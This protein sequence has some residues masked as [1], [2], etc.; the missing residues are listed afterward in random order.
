MPSLC[1]SE[2]ERPVASTTSSA[3]AMREPSPGMSRAAVLGSR[4]WSSA[5]SGATPSAARRAR[6][7]ARMLAGTGGT[8]ASPCVSALKYSPVPPTR[9][10]SRPARCVSAIA[11]CASTHQRPTE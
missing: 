6:I 3:R 9:I 7:D 4:C 2:S 8:A 10:G 5:Y 1:Q 11:A